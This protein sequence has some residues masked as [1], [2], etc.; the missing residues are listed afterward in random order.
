MDKKNAPSIAGI[1]FSSRNLILIALACTA[2][3]LFPTL[4]NDWVNWDDDSYVLRNTLV[5]S[6]TTESIYSHFMTPEQVGHYH[7]LTMISLTIDYFFWKDNAFGFHLTNLV[8]HLLNTILVY[9]FILSISKNQ[10]IAFIVCLL[11]GIHPMHVESV[12]WIS[13]RKDVLYAFLFLAS[14][15]AYLRF[16]IVQVGRYYWY[17]LSIILFAASILSKSLSFTLPIILLLL[18]YYMKRPNRREELVEKVPYFLFGGFGAWLATFGQQ[19]SNTLIG[20]SEF[21]I[22]QTLFLGT[23]N[24]LFYAIKCVVPYPLSTFHPFPSSTLSLP[25]ITYLSIIPAIGVLFLLIKSYKRNAVIFFGITFFLI[26]VG[27][28]LQFIPNGKAIFSERYTYVSYLGLFFIIA[29]GILLLVGWLKQRPSIKNWIFTIILGWV[30]MLCFQS[31]RQSK[32]WKDS[33]TL[34]TQAIEN[35]PESD[36]AYLSRGTYRV[37]HGNYDKALSDLNKSIQLNP[38]ADAHYERGRLQEKLDKV[39]LAF[40]DYT[41]AIKLDSNY[42]MAYVNRGV[43]MSTG[44]DLRLPINDFNQAIR[45]KPDYALAHFN[46]GLMH[47]L[48]GNLEKAL[49]HM[50]DAILLEP[51]NERFLIYRGVVYADLTEYSKAILDFE[52]VMNIAPQSGEPYLLRSY[53]YFNQGDVKLAREDTKTAIRKGHLVPEDYLQKLD[54]SE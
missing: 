25:I 19:A 32:I 9:W 16:R 45:I 39:T 53:C 26:S 15:L 29:H 34:W 50:S 8:F 10:F 3:C 41:S 4:Q 46:L 18:D 38:T 2:F 42:A 20:F 31:Y 1:N 5:H 13:S 12:A 11:F 33:E 37:D 44:N 17:T 27:P 40:A 23:E 21:S 14:I 36:W 30:V 54:I 52:Q 7:P 51:K 6:L 24:A 28:V 49:Q 35:Y 22:S 47:K 43:L 48:S